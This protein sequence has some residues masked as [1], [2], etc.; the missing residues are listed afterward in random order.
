MT[1]KLTTLGAVLALA[2]SA[3]GASTASAGSHER[4]LTKGGVV[5]FDHTGNY[6]GA[7]DRRKDGYAVRAYLNW[8]EVRD[9]ETVLR[10]EEV[11]DDRGYKPGPADP[12]RAVYRKLF[13][14]EGTRVTLTMCYSQGDLNRRC[15]QGQAATARARSSS[16]GRSQDISTERGA[17]WFDHDG[18]RLYAIDTK[19]DG[20]GVQ[21]FLTWNRNRSAS[22]VDRGAHGPPKP[23]DLDLPEGTIVDLQLCY[24]RD[25]GLVKC[26]RPQSAIA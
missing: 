23:K 20:M 16:A 4:I 26:S 14:K 7:L 21:A 18:D 6:I 11:T 1:I 3:I 8:S 10:E 17:A 9:G 13:I 24:F 19:V 12:D 22:V 25:S 2:V 15:S 5:W